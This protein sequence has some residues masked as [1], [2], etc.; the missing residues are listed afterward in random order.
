MKK[1]SLI[2]AMVILASCQEEVKVEVESS[3]C[4]TPYV[5]V[6][7]YDDPLR[8]DSA[9]GL[10]SLSDASGHTHVIRAKKSILAV[11]DTIR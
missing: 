1:L 3:K 7:E 6:M 4:K 8:E 2:A 11:G 10:F 9:M 5:I